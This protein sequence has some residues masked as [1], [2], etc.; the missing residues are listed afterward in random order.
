[1]TLSRKHA[2]CSLRVNNPYFAI[3]GLPA[4]APVDSSG[5]PPGVVFSQDSTC[6]SPINH[7]TA[8]AYVHIHS[9]ATRMHEIS[10]RDNTQL[11][12]ENSVVFHCANVL[13]SEPTAKAPAGSADRT[14]GDSSVYVLSV[15]KNIRPLTFIIPSEAAIATGIASALIMLSKLLYTCLSK[16]W[17][18]RTTHCD[19]RIR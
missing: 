7:K 13:Q 6:V 3:H 14:F 10:R 2:K 5:V 1:M 9:S 19:Q 18:P 4:S 17:Q 16:P 8:C 11:P 15:L 12:D